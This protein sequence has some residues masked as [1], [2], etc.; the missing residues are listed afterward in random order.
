MSKSTSGTGPGV[1]G[2]VEERPRTAK[3]TME[4]GS[5]VRITTGP[6]IGDEGVVR[7]DT[8]AWVLIDFGK[9]GRRRHHRSVLAVAHPRDRPERIEQAAAWLMHLHD[10]GTLE[11]EG[12]IWIVLRDALAAPEQPAGTLPAS[13]Q[14]QPEGG[15]G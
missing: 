5:T 9:G 6:F 13:G 4:N 8:G 14:A 7:D 15:E 11:R 12:V 1:A 10:E 3:P 2:R